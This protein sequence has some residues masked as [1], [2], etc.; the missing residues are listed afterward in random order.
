[1]SSDVIA[2]RDP[3]ALVETD[4][5]EAHLGD[6][7]LRI[8]DCTTYLHPAEPGSDLPYRV[9]SGRADYDKGHIPGAAFLDLQGELSDNS[10]TLRFT[11][12][13]LDEFAARI[14]ALGVGDGTRVVLYSTGT[15][16]WATR[17]WW[18]LR[19]I[20][21][22]AAVLNGGLDKWRAEERPLSTE[23]GRY[24]AA[25]LTPEPRP[26]LFVGKEAVGSA[27]GDPNTCTVNA[28][29]PAFHA[30]EGE[31]RYGRP[32]RVPGSVNV[33]AQ[34][35]VDEESKTFIPLAEAKA[36]FDA[37]GADTS[38]R[39]INYCGGGISATIDI[40]LQHQLGYD[41]ITIYDGSM[42]E[43]A[44]DDSLPIETG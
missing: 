41:D 44:K 35:L 26:E 30:G 9:E 5:L 34:T 11:M 27:I 12:L 4:W 42:G 17:V 7:G 28:L 22:D 40:F 15:M 19:A 10:T 33:F 25:A 23:E 39:I 8:Y 24:P 3:D 1:M 16:M 43:W 38:K 32:G 31:S 14:A 36:R 18:M 37:V 20:G 6:A 2:A 21:F 29:S 13:P